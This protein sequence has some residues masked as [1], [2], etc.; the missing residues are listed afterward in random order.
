VSAYLFLPPKKAEGEKGPNSTDC[1]LNDT[2]D[3][4]LPS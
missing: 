3:H 1:K 4:F 2:V